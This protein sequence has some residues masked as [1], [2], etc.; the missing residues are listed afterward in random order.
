MR[1]KKVY[2]YDKNLALI[3]EFE[4]ATEAEAALG[5]YTGAVYESAVRFKRPFKG[6]QWSYKP[7]ETLTVRDAEIKNEPNPK[8]HTS[9]KNPIYMTE[10]ELKTKH[11]QYTI[12]MNA[13]RQI[14]DGMFIEESKLLKNAGLWG[15]PG[16]RST[17]DRPEFRDYKGK[18][19]GVVYFGSEKSVKKLKMEGVLS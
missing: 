18:A 3:H 4:T 11:D 5:L 7:I 2:G 14:P 12:L 16:Y 8:Q 17:T 1:K 10:S 6:I 13:I 9:V 15:K 19:D